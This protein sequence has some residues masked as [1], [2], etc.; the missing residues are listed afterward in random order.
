MK[1]LEI[2]DLL[3]DELLA[4]HRGF[5]AAVLPSATDRDHAAG[6]RPATVP[7]VG[8]VQIGLGVRRSAST[9]WGGAACT[10]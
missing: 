6:H 1:Y 7:T 4:K 10:G 9:P 2:D 8:V 3:N 5:P